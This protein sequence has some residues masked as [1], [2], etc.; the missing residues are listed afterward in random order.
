METLPNVGKKCDTCGEVVRAVQIECR[1]A[2]ER[3]EPMP[4]Q[5]VCRCIH[6]G[7]LMCNCG[8]PCWSFF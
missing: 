7:D 1:G 8:K 4:Q 3:G 2:R 6:P 5:E